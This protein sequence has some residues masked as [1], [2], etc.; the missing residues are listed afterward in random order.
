MNK[1]VAV[2]REE[3]KETIKEIVE[4][5]GS[6]KDYLRFLNKLRRSTMIQ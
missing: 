5:H 1:K 6:V 2:A 3:R 4:K